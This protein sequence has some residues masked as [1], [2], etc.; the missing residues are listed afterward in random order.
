LNLKITRKQLKLF[1]KRHKVL[2]FFSLLLNVQSARESFIRYFLREG[3]REL[4]GHDVVSKDVTVE[5]QN[6]EFG[7]SLKA[8]SE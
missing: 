1:Q 7:V 4:T 2:I 5:L 8:S 3:L 6:E